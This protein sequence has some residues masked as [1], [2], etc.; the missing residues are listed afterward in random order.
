MCRK[1]TVCSSFLRCPVRACLL[2]DSWAVSLQ[3]FMVFH[4]PVCFLLWVFLA[5]F[6]LSKLRVSVASCSSIIFH[7]GLQQVFCALLFLQLRRFGK[8]LASL[9]FKFYAVHGPASGS[10][11]CRDFCQVLEGPPECHHGAEERDPTRGPR[12][13]GLKRQEHL[14]PQAGK[15]AG[16]KTAKQR[17]FRER[18]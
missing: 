14:A 11:N 8:D 16:A 5:S 2:A 15:G 7:T 12:G 3:F 6:G 13:P 18:L 17:E 1:D 9:L 10:G 4:F